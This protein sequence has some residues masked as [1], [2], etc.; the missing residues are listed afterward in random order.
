MDEVIG[1]GRWFIFYAWGYSQDAHM[2]GSV[3]NFEVS[4]DKK[5]SSH[6]VG[7]RL[8]IW[9]DASPGSNISIWADFL[10]VTLENEICVPFRMQIDLG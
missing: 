10:F 2:V 6:T 7:D 3:G 1:S 8:M 4:L 9:F 5:G